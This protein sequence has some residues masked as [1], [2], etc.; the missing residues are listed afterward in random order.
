MNLRM[1][2]GYTFT[3]AGATDVYYF[4]LED[5]LLQWASQFE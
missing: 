1:G 3:K 5:E 4:P 2:F